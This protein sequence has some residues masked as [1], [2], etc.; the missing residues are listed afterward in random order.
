[1]TYFT[2]LLIISIA[3]TALAVWQS[4]VSDDKF[5]KLT[6]ED[7]EECP[8]KNQPCHVIQCEKE[9]QIKK[10]FNIPK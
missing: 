9:C 5:K 7:K 8:Y 3:L 10:A 1:M 6:G 2:V 4:K